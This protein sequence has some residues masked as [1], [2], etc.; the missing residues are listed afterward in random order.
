VDSFTRYASRRHA[1]TSR[2]S[3]R[4]CLFAFAFVALFALA[5]L[6]LILWGAYP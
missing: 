2:I 3:L 5:H 4:D 6:D 1:P